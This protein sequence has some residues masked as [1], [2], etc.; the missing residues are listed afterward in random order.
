MEKLVDLE[1]FLVR[2]AEEILGR[3]VKQVMPRGDVLKR[4]GLKEKMGYWCWERID[5]EIKFLRQRVG[6]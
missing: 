6:N 3:E 2:G 4:E 5:E 1:E